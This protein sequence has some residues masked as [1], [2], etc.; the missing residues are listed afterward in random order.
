MEKLICDRVL[1]EM[2]GL[3]G[4]SPVFIV[5]QIQGHVCALSELA[6]QLPV[7]AVGVQWTPE[8]PTTSIEEMASKYMKRLVEVQPKGP[9]HL[10]GYSFGAAV[11]FEIATQLQATGASVASLTLLDGAPKYLAA[12]S[13]Q[14]RSMFGAGTKEEEE[15]ALFCS[16]LIQYIDIDV[17][18]VRKQMSQYPNWE[19]KQEAATDILLKASP[20]VRPSRE[21]V[22]T[23]TQVFYDFIRASEAYCPREKYHGDIVLVKASRPQSTARDL[24]PDYG[25]SECCDGKIEVKVVD[26]LHENFILGEG[27]RR[28][29]SIIGDQLKK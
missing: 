1:V 18:E 12:N 29:A 9:Y 26:G 8:I 20:D 17:L 5:H 19:A 21:D 23:A 3:R 10:V 4:A 13:H 14:I 16:F 6:K 27:A 7:R 2:N 22:A 15:T 28:C 25:L 24:P 11:A